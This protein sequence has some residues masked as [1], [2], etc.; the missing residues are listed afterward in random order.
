M[1]SALAVWAGFASHGRHNFFAGRE[2]TALYCS[3][4]IK[5]AIELCLSII[6]EGWMVVVDHSV[7][8]QMRMPYAL[9]SCHAS[10]T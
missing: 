7:L 1:M 10:K 5:N 6:F 3:E 8:H 4:D 2:F 9:R